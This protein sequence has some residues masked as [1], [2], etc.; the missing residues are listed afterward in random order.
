MGPAE[1]NGDGPNPRTPDV[2]VRGSPQRWH[3]LPR[4]TLDL[5]N[6]VSTTCF[7]LLCSLVNIAR[8]RS[9]GTTCEW[10]WSS[11]CPACGAAPF[12]LWWNSVTKPCCVA[13]CESGSLCRC[14]IKG[15]VFPFQGQCHQLMPS[16]PPP[17]TGH[18]FQ[19]ELGFK[20]RGGIVT[21]AARVDAQLVVHSQEKR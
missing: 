13:G 12:L 8:E 4:D 20:E 9:L 2:W 7:V 19:V 10:L 16:G 18:Q 6:Y 15:C 14:L 5:V 17:V 11:G 21:I 3:P 1:Q